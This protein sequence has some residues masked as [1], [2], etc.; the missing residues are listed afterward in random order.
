[1]S[2]QQISFFTYKKFQRKEIDADQEYYLHRDVLYRMLHCC[3][4]TKDP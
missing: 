2:D 4:P 3:N 1:M